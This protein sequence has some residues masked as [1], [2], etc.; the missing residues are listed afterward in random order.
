MHIF[1]SFAANLTTASKISIGTT[2]SIPV[3]AALTYGFWSNVSNIVEIIKIITKEGNKTPRR[4]E[5]APPIP[6]NL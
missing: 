1:L 5:I 4:Q 6:A 3:M 2:P